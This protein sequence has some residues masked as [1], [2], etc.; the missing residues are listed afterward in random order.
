MKLGCTRKL[1][2]MEVKCDFL[3]SITLQDENGNI[4]HQ[5]AAN[6]WRPKVCSTW[7]KL[8]YSRQYYRVGRIEKQD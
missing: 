4:L 8:G 7:R 2:D 5:H 1:V 6:E 3:E